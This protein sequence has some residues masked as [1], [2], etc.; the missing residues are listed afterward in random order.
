VA[1]LP[2]N[3][4]STPANRYG[5]LK[6]LPQHPFWLHHGSGVRHSSRS[7]TFQL[8]DRLAR[9]HAQGDARPGPRGRGVQPTSWSDGTTS[10]DYIL[11]KG[12]WFMHTGKCKLP[13]VLYR[14][15]AKHCLRVSA[16]WSRKEILDVKTTVPAAGLPPSDY[17]TRLDQWTGTGSDQVLDGHGLAQ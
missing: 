7:V 3:R 9:S 5:S 8:D 4:G 11:A 17:E 15:D 6:H 2:V 1:R 13:A 12:L 14:D 10:L 16:P